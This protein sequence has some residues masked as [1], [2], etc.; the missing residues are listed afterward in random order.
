MLFPSLGR[1]WTS[2]AGPRELNSDEKMEGG[3]VQSE[4]SLF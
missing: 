3:G 1:A 2:T 4:N